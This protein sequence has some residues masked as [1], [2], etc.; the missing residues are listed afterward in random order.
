MP[1]NP[2][3]ETAVKTCGF[4][5]ILAGPGSGKTRVIT[6]KILHLIDQGIP[7]NQ[8][9]ALTFSD[10]AASEMSTRIEEK[11]PH[12]DLA[13]HTFP[14]FCLDILRGNVLASGMS[15]P[16]GIISRTTQLVRGLR[17]I[18]PFGLTHIQVG[19]NSAGVIEAV[20]DR[21]SAFRDGLITPAML[22]EYLERKKGMD[23][24]GPAAAIS[25]IHSVSNS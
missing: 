23:G 20:I 22:A 17:D 1:L 19:N 21:I 16:G 13:V 2:S 4:Q 11:R 14:T 3:Q 12:L 18:D 24:T 7:P 8:I 9:L 15:V 6:E 10:K 25:A 5:L